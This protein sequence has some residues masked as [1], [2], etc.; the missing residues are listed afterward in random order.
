MKFTRDSL[1]RVTEVSAW[2]WWERTFRL[3]AVARSNQV[4][5]PVGLDSG[6]FGF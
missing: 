4:Q 5:L 6:R 2:I 1:R 3:A